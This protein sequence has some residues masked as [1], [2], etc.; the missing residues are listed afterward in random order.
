M[1]PDWSIILHDGVII[2]IVGIL[3]VF[4]ALLILFKV[5]AWISLLIS[6]N[7]RQKLR[8]Q[9]KFAESESHSLEVPGDHSA[10]IAMALYLYNEL[11]DEESNILTI[12]RKSRY[13]SPW[14]SK[15][16]NMRKPSR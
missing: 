7:I 10:A 12:E 16:Y 11:H 3:I 2:S 8:R 6:M 14:S 15:Y 4:T 5:F 13:Y 9:G 1:K